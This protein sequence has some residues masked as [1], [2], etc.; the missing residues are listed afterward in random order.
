MSFKGTS[1]TVNYMLNPDAVTSWSTIFQFYRERDCAMP[2]SSLKASARNEWH[3]QRLLDYLP[4][5]NERG[6]VLPKILLY[7]LAR[8]GLEFRGIALLAVSG[9]FLYLF[10]TR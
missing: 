2:S 5:V 7:A 9:F 6:L 3:S 4:H 8:V 10:L 1:H